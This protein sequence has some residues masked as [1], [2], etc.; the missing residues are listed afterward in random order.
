MNMNDIG[1][2][3]I[4]LHPSEVE[5]LLSWLKCYPVAVRENERKSLEALLEQSLDLVKHK[6]PATSSEFDLSMEAMKDYCVYNSGFVRGR[7]AALQRAAMLVEYHAFGNTGEPITPNCLIERGKAR[8]A[9][10]SI[11]FTEKDVTKMPF[12]ETEQP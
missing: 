12:Y 9:I 4:S 11:K 3:M 1:K 2:P 10:L 7:D 8:D 5:R 6:K